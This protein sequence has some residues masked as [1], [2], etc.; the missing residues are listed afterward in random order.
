[1]REPKSGRPTDRR[2]QAFT[3]EAV[4]ASV[5]IL[6]ALL[7]ALQVSGVSSLAASTSSGQ[8]LEQ[9]ESIAAGVLDS[10]A[11]NDSIDPMLRYWDD[12]EGTFHGSSDDEIY[13]TVG[14]PTEFGSLLNET[15]RDQNLAYNINIQY[16]DIDGTVDQQAL[17]RN[18]VPS[19]DAARATRTVTLYDDDRLLTAD[20]SRSDTTLSEASF[21]A[22][23]RYPDG[24]LYNVVRV[25]V[26]VW[27]V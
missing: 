14:P 25:E 11:A 10:A 17:V 4:V 6:G 19:D 20:G 27:P 7:F 8:L 15:L 12:N 23:D 5:V 9:Q 3:L 1:M 21:Y 2:G 22:P 16:V 24:P 13:Y 26:V 18:G